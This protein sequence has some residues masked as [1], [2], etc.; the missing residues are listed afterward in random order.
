[1]SKLDAPKADF[2]RIV[3]TYLVTYNKINKL[4]RIKF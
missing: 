4:V 1:M 3:I 2:S